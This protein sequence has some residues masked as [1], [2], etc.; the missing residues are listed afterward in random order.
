M[1]VSCFGTAASLGALGAYS[2]L[3]QNGFDVSSYRWVP[4]VTFS[5]GIF[6]ASIGILALPFLIL[7]E[8]LPP[9]VSKFC[10]FLRDFFV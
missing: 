4:V 2:Y 5:A 9:E 7:A 3:N 8:I 6:L 1:L 10:I